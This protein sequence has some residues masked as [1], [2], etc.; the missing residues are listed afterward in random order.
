MILAGGLGTRLRGVVA[1]RP[2]VLAPVRG[3]PFLTYLLDQLA[4]AAIRQV[5]LLTGFQ[6]ERVRAELG[7]TYGPLSLTYAVEPT[8]LGTAGALRA[9]ATQL[10]TR[11]V[12]LLNGDSY[13]PVD[14]PALADC[15]RRRGADLSLV[16]TCVAD[17]GRFGSVATDPEGRV[18]DFREKQPGAGPGWINAGIYLLETDLV[19]DIPPGRAVSLEQEMLPGWVRDRAVYGQ[20]CEGPF[21]DIGTPESYATAAAFL[22]NV[23]P[24]PR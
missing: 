5:V 8:P 15:H 21:L 11:Q 20:R 12:L 10:A 6:A 4:A 2:K 19:Q 17:A 24:R 14:L 7:E 9:A 16:L 3:R 13:C 18:T 22:A 1:D 23:H